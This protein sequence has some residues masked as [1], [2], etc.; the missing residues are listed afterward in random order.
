MAK[1]PRFR[2]P[3]GPAGRTPPSQPAWVRDFQA[4]VAAHN[5]GRLDEAEG[6]YR[7]VLARQPT[8]ADSLSFLGVLLQQRG[9]DLEEAARLTGD[10]LAQDRRNP[11]YLIHHANALQAAGRLDEAKAAYD[12]ALVINP[13]SADALTNLGCILRTQGSPAEAEPYHRRALAADPN[14]AIA[15]QNLSAALSDLGRKGEAVESIVAAIR[16]NPGLA[17]AHQGLAALMIDLQRWGDAVTALTHAL[18]LAPNDATMLSAMGTAVLGQGQVQEALEWQRR[19]AAAAP[20]NADYQFNLGN[21]LVA[22]G[23]PRA[24][25]EAFR[26]AM[27]LRPTHFAAATNLSHALAQFAGPEEREALLTEASDGGK[28]AAARFSRGVLRL[29]QGNLLQGWPDY[30]AR[31][32]GDLARHG[33]RLDIPLWQGTDI[34][35]R[36][37]LIWREQ[38]IGD[39]IMFAT[40]LAHL[41]RRHARMRFI[42]ECTDR[43]AGLF[44][45]A[46]ADRPNLEVQ[47]ETGGDAGAD[48]HRSLG[49]VSSLLRNRLAGFVHTVLPL[50]P[51][52]DLMGAWRARLDGLP[53]GLRVG[54][55]WRSRLLTRDRLGSY[56]L[57]EDLAPLFGLAGVQW[58][59]LQAGL[60]P[61]ER[62]VLDQ[63]GWHLHQWDDLDLVNDLEG[64]AAL[65]ATLDLVVSVPTAVGEMAAAVGTPTWRLA[66][67]RDWT[68]LG[69][70]VRPWYPAQRLVTPPPGQGF[71]QLPQHV[72]TLLRSLVA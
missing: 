23:D 51:R 32:M 17:T 58:V 65:S 52:E 1:S 24:A 66:A 25:V 63:R 22:A 2:P 37:V 38:G 6:L 47:V 67:G 44:T 4:A 39:E 21:S 72:A 42:F 60:A 19:A 41:A 71:A 69:T 13:R 5:A 12:R 34:P 33:R 18:R 16:L 10:A 15:H 45:R 8:H 14:H 59:G 29:E 70:P 50:K 3:P 7:A 43:L 46:F 68:A 30:D 31:F 40:A 9:G 36:T 28:L 64:V 61:E 35:N 27:R 48:M 55:C 11:A 57:L 20:D 26:A 49:G 54:L 56:L 53:P 62:A